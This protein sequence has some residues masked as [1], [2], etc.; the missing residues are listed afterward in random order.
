MAR[1]KYF[2]ISNICIKITSKY[3]KAMLLSKVCH[4]FESW[5]LE[6]LHYWVLQRPCDLVSSLQLRHWA[7]FWILRLSCQRSVQNRFIRLHT[8][9]IEVVKTGLIKINQKVFLKELKLFVHERSPALL[10]GSAPI[11]TL[12][13]YS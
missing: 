2:T 1:N 8:E 4:K 7:N 9:V 3:G 11:W 13:K 5:L 6:E 12:N 10:D